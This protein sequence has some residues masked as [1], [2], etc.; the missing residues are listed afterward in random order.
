MSIGLAQ[1]NIDKSHDFLMDVSDPES[2]NYAKYW[3]PEKVR[4]KTANEIPR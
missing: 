2:P 1:Q 4:A 3:R